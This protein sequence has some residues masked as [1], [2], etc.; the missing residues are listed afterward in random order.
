MAENSK[1]E[2]CD[3]TVS[4]WWGCEK[5]SAACKNCYADSISSRFGPSIW[6]ASSPRK[7]IKG[8]I[9]TLRA[10]DH[11]ARERDRIDTVFINSMSEESWV[12]VRY[13][14]AIIDR[15]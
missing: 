2:W 13:G 7:K 9:G 1:I 8:A 15:T 10:L 6:G 3:H 12:G 4:F 11:K 5:V 14:P